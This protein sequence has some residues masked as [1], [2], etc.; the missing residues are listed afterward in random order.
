LTLCGGQVHAIR[1][2]KA[3]VEVVLQIGPVIETRERGAAPITTSDGALVVDIPRH[4][5]RGT[6]RQG[7]VAVPV[8]GQ[9]GIGFQELYP[10]IL[11]C[12]PKDGKERIGAVRKRGLVG[13]CAEDAS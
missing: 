10:A 3:R 12:Y 8:D 5:L 7:A 2:I 6:W 11:S 1:E 4:D 9:G 13:G